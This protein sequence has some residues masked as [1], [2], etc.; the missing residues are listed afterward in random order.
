MHLKLFFHNCPLMDQQRAWMYREQ[1]VWCTFW[2]LLQLLP[3][4]AQWFALKV[5]SEQGSWGWGLL[6]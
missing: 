1:R 6:F 2:L 5:D 3:S 4:H